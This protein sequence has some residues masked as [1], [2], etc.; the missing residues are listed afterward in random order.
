M[1]PGVK[2]LLAAFAAVAAT[3]GASMSLAQDATPPPTAATPA[4]PP[5]LP[6]PA[7]R[8]AAPRAHPAVQAP[9]APAAPPPHANPGARLAA[10]QTI[11]PAEL[12]AFVDGLAAEAMAR[13][14]IAGAVV[15]V[16]QNGQMVLNKGYGRD[17][18]AP[19]RAVDPDRTLFRLGGITSTFTWIGLMREIEAGRMRLDAPINLYLPQQDQVPDQGFAQ[20]ILLKELLTQSSGFERRANGQLMEKDPRRIRPLDTYLKQERPRRVRPPGSLPAYTDYAAALAGEALTQVTGK[21]PQALAEAEI[22]GPLRLRRTTIREPYPARA[23]LPAPMDAR[24]AADVSEGFSWAGWGQQRRPFEYMTQIAPAAAGSSTG[25]D[26]GRYMMAIL[27]GGVLDGVSIYSPSI[28]KDFRTPLWRP[29]PGVAASDYG[30]MEHPLP[31]GFQGFGREGS[32]LSFRANLVTVP[33][34]NLGVFVAA[35]TQGSEGFTAQAPIQ[36]VGRFYAPPAPPVPPPSDWLRQNASAF[37]GVY[38]STAR[39]YRGLER[40]VGL[41][42]A[43]AKVTITGDGLLL[44][45]SAIGETLWSP[46]KDASTD[47]PYVTFH[48]V[49]GPAALIFKMQDGQ[50]RMWFAPSGQAAYER[51]AFWSHRWLLLGMGALAVLASLIAVLGLF[52]RDRREFRQTSVQGRADAAQISASILWITAM[53]GYLAWHGTGAD[54]AAL[55]FGWPGAWLLIASACALVA[56]I[57]TLLCLILLPIAWRGGRRLDSWTLGRKARFTF[58]TLLFAAFS[59]VLGLWGALEP[60]SR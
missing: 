56:S 38:F 49:G 5:D 6:R 57:M 32:T 24:L 14:H 37:T 25:A 43:G 46:D 21:T 36:I 35:N 60:W 51:S 13:D 44:T 50:A 28:A 52:L 53:A 41:L 17:R 8:H 18:L 3:L 33:E 26:M 9:V 39:A 40:F 7:V 22:T 23:D 11:P 59:V 45:R 30:F 58:T 47:A 54:P 15:T 20:P 34:L 55:M 48:E 42:R 31:G 27:G 12:E 29:A 10:G 1:A 19:A 4:S 2:A 16:V